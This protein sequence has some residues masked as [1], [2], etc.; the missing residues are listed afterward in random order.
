MQ[1]IMTDYVYANAFAP[2]LREARGEAERLGLE[3]GV[4]V[5][6]GMLAEIATVNL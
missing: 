5:I 4:R 2:V 3:I 6:D 1:N